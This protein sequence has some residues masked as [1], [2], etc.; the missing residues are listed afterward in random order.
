M[1]VVK[2]DSGGF[3]SYELRFQSLHDAGRAYSFP[4]DAA[5]H[6]NMDA[7]T[8]VARET[9]LFA[10]IVAGHAV[11]TPSV[12]VRADHWRSLSGAG[13]FRIDPMRAADL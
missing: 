10:R 6:V 11:S 9:Y 1:N 5:G 8:D 2:T 7:L 4:C 12:I 3:A 13:A